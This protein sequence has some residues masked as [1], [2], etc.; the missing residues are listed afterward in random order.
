MFELVVLLLPG[1]VWGSIPEIEEIS[2]RMIF[3][4]INPRT[5][6]ILLNH[7]K[8]MC[9]NLDATLF[10]DFSKAFDSIHWEKMEQIIQAYCLLKENV[11]VSMMLYK[12]A[13][14]IVHSPDGDRLLQYCYRSFARRYISTIFVYNLPRLCTL[15]VDRSNKRK[16]L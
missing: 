1:H 7:R 16:W 9:K 6:Q 15:N 11:T 2:S 10:V 12:N 4:E 5:S 8:S 13:K 14:V 3:G